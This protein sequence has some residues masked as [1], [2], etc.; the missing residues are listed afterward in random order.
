MFNNKV[1]LVTGGSRGIGLATA[2]AFYE[3]GAAVAVI[4]SGRG[5]LSEEVKGLLGDKFVEFACDVSSLEQVGATVAKVC[6]QLGSVDVLVNCAGITKDTLLLSMKE[7]DFDQ[8]IDVNLKGTFNFMKAIYPIMMKKRQGKIINMSSIVG[9]HGNKGQANYSASKAGV[10]G[11]TKSVAL[12][13]ASRGINVNAV[14]PGFIE[15]DMTS[16]IS[17]KAKEEMVGAIPMK[18]K[19]T[20]QDIANVCLFLASEQASYITG[21]VIVIDGGLTI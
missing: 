15:T 12:E 16:S 19:G 9:L 14:A 11:L 1:V 13:L 3:Q 20:P 21:Q 5:E 2:K 10:I 17:E 6:E 4:H 8:V 7:S 18:R